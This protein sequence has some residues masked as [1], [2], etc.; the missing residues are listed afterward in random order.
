MI[1]LERLSVPQLLALHA[2]ITQALR[3]RAITRTSNNP[4]GDLAELL[5]CTAFRWQRHE[6]SQAHVDATGRGKCYQIKGRRLTAHNPSRQLSAIRDLN[7]GH[8]DFLAGVLF[9]EDFTV[10]R[11]A[12]IPC[13]LV[14]ERAS[15]VA[16]TNSHRFLLKD[17][18]WNAPGV[19]DVTEKLRA[20]NLEL[21]RPLKPQRRR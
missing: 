16:R 18:V 8:F 5:F 2:R 12:I 7:D 15:F 13:A 10:L 21:Q 3:D 20:V 9:K 1:N 4:V 11:A 19:R 6:N 17:D 14:K